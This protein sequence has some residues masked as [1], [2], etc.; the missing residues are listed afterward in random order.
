[1]SIIHIHR[2]QALSDTFLQEWQKLTQMGLDERGTFYLQIRK[3]H[4]LLD[5]LDRSVKT[6]YD[7]YGNRLPNVLICM[8]GT[9]LPYRQT[10]VMCTVNKLWYSTKSLYSKSFQSALPFNLKKIDIRSSVDVGDQIRALAFDERASFFYDDLDC[11]I[12]VRDAK[13]DADVQP[14]ITLNED[15][16]HIKMMNGNE[17]FIYEENNERMMGTYHLKSET[18]EKWKKPSDFLFSRWQLWNNQVY[19][20]SVKK[21]QVAVC[22]SKGQLLYKSDLELRWRFGKTV[23][24]KVYKD[25]IYLFNNN[26]SCDVHFVF[27]GKFKRSFSLDEGTNKGILITFV[28]NVF[29]LWTLNGLYCYTLTGT[30]LF[31][32]LCPM[33]GPSSLHNDGENLYLCHQTFS[34]MSTVTFKIY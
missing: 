3:L 19:F 25:E 6:V 5:S 7:F 16:R 12:C 24:I 2:L 14:K 32:T 33:R 15:V 22:N 23:N 30:Q 11:E 13:T 8:I 27:D 34:D 31:R 18:I 28:R 26:G 21:D 20:Y 10:R 4:A 17:C 29:F 9:F 1:M